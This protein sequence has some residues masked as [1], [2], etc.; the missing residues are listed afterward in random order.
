MN[1]AFIPL[2]GFVLLVIVLG[3]GLTIDPKKVPSVLIDKPAPKFDLPH[4]MQGGR[5]ST[6]SM[7]GKVW[8]MNVWASW[9]VACRAEHE[10]IKHLAD[11]K[12][13]DIVG[14]NYKDEAGDARSWLFDFGNPYTQIAVDYDG[15]TGINFGVYGVP[16][17]FLIDKQ[18][19]IRYK[20]IGPVTAESLEKELL[21]EIKKL[22]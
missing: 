5:I 16:E 11:M 8:V 7:L 21:P 6:E 22:L 18:G 10:I 20:H 9:C 2:I 14:L 3:I 13:V 19:Y 15:R 17:S 4:L 12:I 1:K